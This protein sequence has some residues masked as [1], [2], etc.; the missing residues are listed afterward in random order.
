VLLNLSINF[1][2]VIHGFFSEFA[3]YHPASLVINFLFFWLFL[4][5]AL[6]YRRWRET[7]RRTVE[8]ENVISCIS[9]DTL[10]VVTPDRTIAVCNDSVKRVFGYEPEEVINRKT[11]LLYFDRRVN[12][13][14]PREIYDALEHDGFH[15]G[16]A[17]GRRKNGE[18]FPLEIIAGQLSGRGGAVLLLRDITDRAR[19]AE[20]RRK[21]EDRMR[22]R[23]K[24]E[25]LGILAGGIAHHFNN[26]LMVVLGNAEIATEDIPP[27]S[28]AR[29]SM[30]GIVTA[31]KH[32]AQLCNQL[33]AYSGKAKFLIQPLSLSRVVRT[34]GKLLAVPISK[35]VVLK[36]KLDPELPSIEA[37]PVQ[38]HQVIMNLITNASEA[39]G[40]NEGTISITTGVTTCD[41]RFLQS[42]YI[43]EQLPS[44]EYVFLEVRD[45]GCG[46]D[47]QT[48]AK[49]FDPFFTTKVNGR[50]LGLA[51][52][53]GV[54]RGH[55][56]TLLVEGDSGKGTTFTVL[57]PQSA[58]PVAP[59][60]GTNH[61]VE[62]RKGGTILVAEDQET[63]RELASRILGRMGF[64]II[65]ASDGRDA[66]EVFRRHAKDIVAV[67]LD[68]T[69]PKLNGK[70]AFREIMKIR[71]D[72]R[73]I[74]SSGY[75][76]QDVASQFEGVQP[77]GFI[78][79]PFQVT[80]L[81]TKLAQ[82]LEEKSRS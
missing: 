29:E 44:G 36:Y 31:A 47:E 50:G 1:L 14:R 37:D 6:A 46:M 4:L 34:M 73:V 41:D 25:S 26:L 16:T 51:S 72:A 79:K 11:D 48:R 9:P 80:T 8:L 40:D 15:V 7:S 65:T 33:L 59:D 70:E 66:V 42:C 74:L 76:E 45:T 17:T 57:F 55:R 12:R 49:I 71:P 82:V 5:L 56:G 81:R 58:E 68:M 63:V 61:K 77:A 23:Q 28:P 75:S 54:M 62:T 13:S 18:T 3:Q 22:H 10:M 53:L 32:A 52:V 30:A 69:M 60:N 64:K 67:L 20:E 35:K 21:L 78:Q 43:D 39:I 24:L 38:V 19:T 27:D 2:D